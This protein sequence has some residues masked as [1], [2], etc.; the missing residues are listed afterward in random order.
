MLKIGL[1]GGIG[2]GKSAVSTIFSENKIP[3]YNSDQ[4]AKWLMNN[5]SLLKE[6]IVNLFDSQA[7]QDDN[8]NRSYISSI[9]FNDSSKLIQLNKLVHPAVALDFEQWIHKNKNTSYIVKEAA[10][11]IESEA[12][13]QMDVIIL[14]VCDESKR[15][16]RV[17]QR[18]NSSLKEVEKRIA[19]QLSDENKMK[20]A[21]YVINNEGNLEDLEENVMKVINKIKLNY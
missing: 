17:V 4:R 8:L 15:I 6:K 12:Y 3:V 21:D 19:K 11:L 10:I 7:Y 14:V 9:V 20:F 16:E 13:K 5:D 18:D 2:S 1:T